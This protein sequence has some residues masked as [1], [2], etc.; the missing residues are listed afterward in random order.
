MEGLG[1]ELTMHC[2]YYS[3]AYP[4]ALVTLFEGLLGIESGTFWI[5]IKSPYKPLEI[6]TSKLGKAK[7]I[8][9]W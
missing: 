9:V 4:L 7:E 8:S 1:L 2:V 5:S 6:L 3:E